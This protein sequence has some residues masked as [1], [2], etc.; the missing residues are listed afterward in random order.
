M[1]KSNLFEVLR[2]LRKSEFKRFE[3]LIKSPYYSKNSNVFKLFKYVKKFYPEF[4]NDKLKKEI[5]W[6]G[7]FK[8]RKFNYGI[9]KNL[10]H[11]LNKLTEKFLELQEYEKNEFQSGLN[12][13]SQLRQRNL[14]SR[15]E[16]LL[17]INKA[18]FFGA[19]ISIDYY[20]YNNRIENVEQ[21]YLYQ[22]NKHKDINYERPE[23]PNTYL[24]SYFFS[25]YLRQNHAALMSSK[26]FNIEISKR[27][28]EIMLEFFEK[29]DFE[30]DILTMQ[31]YYALK[32]V[33]NPKDETIYYEAKKIFLK[34]LDRLNRGTKYDIAGLFW[35]YWSIQRMSGNMKFNDEQFEMINLMLKGNFYTKYENNYFPSHFFANI[36]AVACSLGHISWCYKFVNEY[37]DKVNPIDKNKQYYFGMYA[38]NKAE[39]KFEGALKC[40]SKLKPSNVMEKIS[41][42]VEEL[43]TYYDLKYFDEIYSLIKTSKEYVKHDKASSSFSIDGFNY[44]L[45]FIKKLVDININL[46]SEK[47]DRHYFNRLK[48][49]ITEKQFMSKSWVLSR[50]NVL[51]ESLK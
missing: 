17:K 22:F 5:I 32:L 41:I 28:V 8:G 27:E 26:Y 18:K 6:N 44:L 36:I 35:S 39:N 12:L 49:E 4:E 1:L 21:S 51:E 19:E 37:Y 38:I 3:E 42:K 31:Y 23:N 2:T 11:E 16:K 25:T 50:L 47:Y 40:L 24:F 14:N 45:D 46:G 30:K 33:L 48:N 10:I 15:F 13:L 34:N 20:Y 7:I 29:N 43:K 9:M